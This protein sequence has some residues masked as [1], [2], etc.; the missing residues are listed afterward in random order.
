MPATMVNLLHPEEAL[1]DYGPLRCGL[2]GKTDPSVYWID[3]LKTAICHRC[4]VDANRHELL[5]PR[6]MRA[7]NFLSTSEGV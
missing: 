6:V 1:E 4:E 5:E 2:C 7:W 3:F